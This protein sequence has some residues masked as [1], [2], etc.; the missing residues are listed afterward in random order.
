MGSVNT[1]NYPAASVKM[2]NQAMGVFCNRITGL[3]NSRW[4][5]N[6]IWQFRK[7]AQDALAFF[8]VADHV[9]LRSILDIF[10][11]CINNNLLPDSDQTKLLLL[12]SQEMQNYGVATITESDLSAFIPQNISS[13]TRIETP[14]KAFWRQW[15]ERPEM[16]KTDKVSMESTTLAESNSPG[17]INMNNQY[18]SKLPFDADLTVSNNESAHLRIYHLTNYNKLSLEL[19]QLIEKEGMDLELLDTLE[20]LVELLQALPAN[21]ILIDSF[22]YEQHDAIKEAVTAYK[23]L[24]ITPI[25]VV[26]IIDDNIK[27]KD[28]NKYFDVSVNASIGAGSIV[29]QIDQLLRFGKADQFRVLIV[30]D[31][32]SQAMFAEGILRNA[33]ITTKVL[34]DSEYLL[35]SI[36]EFIP[37]LILMDL[38][39]PNASGIELT[40]LIRSS[41]CFQN[42]PIVFL[43]GEIDED[44]QL[45]ALEAGGDDFLI[46]PIRPRRLITAVQSRIKRHRALLSANSNHNVTSV[47]SGLINRSDILDQIRLDIQNTQKALLFIDINGYGL[48]KGK[49]GL[50]ALENLLKTFSAFL[51]QTCSPSPVARFGDGTFVLIYEGDCTESVLKAYAL[52]LRM[53]LMVE[54]FE[55][56]GHT[57]ELRLH[58]G[59]CHFESASGDSDLLLNVAEQTARKAINKNSGIDIYKPQSHTEIEREEHL[60]ELLNDLDKN[61]CLSHVYQP[62]VAVAG[63]EEKQFQTLLRLQDLN[64][65]IIPAAEFI[66]IAEKSNLIVSLDRWS[67]S[68]AIQV[69]VE[70]EANKEEIKLFV[71]QSN[72]TLLYSEQLTWL[73]N[74]LK[75]NQLPENSLVIEINHEDALLNQQSIQEFCK[76]LIYDRVQFCLSR[77][78]PRND[79]PNLLENL[80]I[81]YIKLAHKLTLELSTQSIKD[82]VKTLVDKA[83]L[84]GLEVIG[85][86]VEDAQTAAT[87]WMNGIDYIQGNLVQSANNHL[88][89]GFDQSVL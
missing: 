19:D 44:K 29:K 18:E 70:N 43:S 63:S 30:E 27:V 2:Q 74:L 60:I 14:P 73:K 72:I 25:T 47:G 17:M 50:T 49:L 65:D 13:S 89:F 15:T 76:A 34:L 20:E 48:L 23:K 33:E 88:E 58:I 84:L 83:H 36:E 85:H 39:M 24:N 86:S 68:K 22:F 10:D 56:M 79:E 38:H 61:N 69:I 59:I 40:E 28:S 35:Q 32:R 7:D 31:D 6:A 41:D 45:D 12:L 78:N 11:T 57:I 42:K 1:T 37:D 5:L 16:T 4:D 80:P 62:I 87:L 51:V 53:R 81:S 67:I 75:A 52:K 21:L 71:N 77:Y 64:G 66:P 8:E 9:E 46:K 54:K 55:V 3:C 82:E 26:Q